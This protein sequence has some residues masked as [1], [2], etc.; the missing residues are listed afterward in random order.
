MFEVDMQS[1]SKQST[2]ADIL[3]LETLKMSTDVQH[4]EKLLNKIFGDELE[5]TRDRD[6]S[7]LI[8]FPIKDDIADASES[9]AAMIQDVADQI[10]SHAA[11]VAIGAEASKNS[12]DFSPSSFDIAERTPVVSYSDSRHLTSIIGEDESDSRLQQVIDFQRKE[13]IELRAKLKD[14]DYDIRNLDL[15]IAANNDQLKYMPELFNK[16]L[17]ATQLTVKVKELEEALELEQSTH[18]QSRDLLYKTQA[19]VDRIKETVWFKLGRTFGFA[20]E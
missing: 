11:A 9:L 20:G 5:K 18:E 15:Q 12:I 3:P 14:R 16:A 1:F 13:L 6:E 17:V 8:E 4:L 10:H 7:N 2:E 19:R